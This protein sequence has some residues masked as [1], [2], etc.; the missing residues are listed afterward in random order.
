MYNRLYTINCTPGGDK[1]KDAVASKVDGDL[2][3]IIDCLNDHDEN[4]SGVHGVGAGDVVG[5][6]K[7]QTLTNKT[8]SAPAVTDFTSATHDH[9][10]NAK[11]GTVSHASL[12]DKGANTHAQIDSHLSS[13]ATHGATGAVVGT[14]NTQTLSNKTLQAPAITDFTGAGHNHAAAASGGQLDH[15]NLTNKGT[16]THAQI[17]SH[18]S[19]TAQHGA[20]GA[21]VGTTNTQTLTNKT[22]Q[23]PAIT[24]FTSAGHTHANAAGGGQLDHVNLSNKGTNTHAQIDSH[25]SGTTGHGAAGAVVGTT[26]TQTLTNKTLQAPT[27]TDFTSATHSHAS[28]AGGGVLDHVNLNNIGTNTHAQIDSHIS[29]TAVHGATGAVVGTTNTQTLTNKTLTSPTINAG[30]LYGGKLVMSEN[31]GDHAY[32]GICVTGTAGENLAQGDIVYKKLNGGAWKWYKY[33]ANGTYKN[34]LPSGIATAAIS[35]GASGSIL[36]SGQMRDDTW[37]LSASADAAVT[38]YTSGTPGGVTLTPPGT[39]GD[40]VM[41]VGVLV[42]GNTILTR[43]GFGWVE[44]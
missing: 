24:D 30:S 21:V 9:S 41:V 1:V 37:S 14:T 15:T 36:V 10:S 33:D 6:D 40:Q 26:N 34:I 27:I 22:L 11:G 7:S 39:A 43:F 13:T 18:I 31:L 42:G 3:H 35:S 44:V 25:I 16:N 32:E 19:S 38:V 4:V 8:L 12:G 17:D 29:G 2:T 23:A 28:N 5:T 20:A